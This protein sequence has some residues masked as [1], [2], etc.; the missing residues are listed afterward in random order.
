[1]RRPHLPLPY[2]SRAHGRGFTLIELMI[3]VVIIGLI[4]VIAIPTLAGD[5]K[6][7]RTR[8]AAEEIASLFR[9]ARMR[10]LGRGAAVMVHY[11]A[12]AKSFSVREAVRGGATTC[13]RLPE[14][15]CLLPATRWTTD[16]TTQGG[17]Q[18]VAKIKLDASTE[19]TGLKVSVD[20]PGDI[21]DVSEFSVCFSPVGRSFIAYGAASVTSMATMTGVPTVRVYRTVPGQTVAIGLERR[22]VILPDGQARL[23]VSGVR[24]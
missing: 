13:A 24:E 14:T 22:V 18:E 19:Q 5:L 2:P 16:A 1:V 10:A 9:N 11:D 8:R 7:R 17:S 20:G 23:E 4:A 15:N 12:S 3:V 21:K 6:D